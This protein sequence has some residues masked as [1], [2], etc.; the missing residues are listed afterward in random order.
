MIR[1]LT[2]HDLPLASQLGPKFY[3]EGK[4]PG[5]FVPEIFVGTWTALIERGLGFILGLFE[6]SRLCGC[7]GAAVTKCLND[8]KL[9]ANEMFWFVTPEARGGGLR[10]VDEYEKEAVK[11]GAVRCS[12]A[13]LKGL[14]PDALGRFYERRG[15]KA[16]EIAYS[17]EL[18]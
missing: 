3:A 7:I 9:T 14:H 18:K 11:R 5:E 6:N 10:M 17:K 13:L 8:G 2:I 1:L 12:M 15:Y 4:L 16:F